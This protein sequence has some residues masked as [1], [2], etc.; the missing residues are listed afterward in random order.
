MVM[1]HKCG[2]I[3][4][5][6]KDS[7]R[8]IGFKAVVNLLMLMGT[9]MKENLIVTKQTAKEFTRSQMATSTMGSGPRISDMEKVN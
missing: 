1:E 5:S 2:L 3:A 7:G 4:L 6:M 9:Y 8:M